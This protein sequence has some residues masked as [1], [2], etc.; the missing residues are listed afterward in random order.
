MKAVCV[1]DWGEV[2][3]LSCHGG[4]FVIGAACGS[5]EGGEKSSVIMLKDYEIVDRSHD[6]IVYTGHHRIN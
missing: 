4:C 3:G 1:D 5:V 2:E 6:I